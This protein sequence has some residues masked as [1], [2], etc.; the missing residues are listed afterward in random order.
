MKTSRLF[1][2]SMGLLALC[3][4]SAVTLITAN[5]SREVVSLQI[6][7]LLSVESPLKPVERHS[8]D[9]G[10]EHVGNPALIP[11]LP[12]TDYGTTF[13]AMNDHDVPCPPSDAPDVVY[14]YVPT[15]MLTVNVSLCGSS[16]NTR[17]FAFE[18]DPSHAVACN[19]DACGMQS[20][21]NDL[22]LT[23]GHQYFFVVDGF[24]VEAGDYVINIAEAGCNVP[25]QPGDIIECPETPNPYHYAEDCDGGCH[26]TPPVFGAILP[27][28]PLCGVGFTYTCS[29]GQNCR[30]TDWHEFVVSQTSHVSILLEA[31]FP[32][33]FGIVDY[34]PCDSADLLTYAQ[35][36]EV[37]TPTIITSECLPP[38]NYVAFVAPM[39]FTGVPVPMNYRATL[40]LETCEPPC[41]GIISLSEDS[42]VFAPAYIGSLSVGS[43]IV[44]N[45][46]TEPLCVDSVTTTGHVWQAIP[47]SFIV[48]PGQL[49][50]VQVNFL[51]TF[52]HAF[53]G[54]IEFFS[55]D[56]EKPRDSIIVSGTGCHPAVEPPGPILHSAACPTA[57]YFELPLDSN[58]EMTKYMVE[59]SLD[60]F[61]T[62]DVL[63]CYA[64]YEDDPFWVS[65]VHWGKYGQGVILDLEAS[66]TYQVR[67]H[68]KDC[69][70]IELIGPAASIATEPAIEVAT[71]PEL[72]IMYVNENT[73]RLHWNP[74]VADSAGNELPN[75]GY[76]VYIGDDPDTVD[77]LVDWSLNGTVDMALNSWQRGFLTVDPVLEGIYD[78]PCPFI[79]WPPEGA[80]VEGW[81]CIVLQDF[82]HFSQ[83]DSFRIEVNGIL[84]GSS[85]DNP[86]GWNSRR[87]SCIDFR[88][89]SSG[90]ATI[91]A[92]VVDKHN[93][94][95]E[96]MC[97]V[98]VFNSGF[99]DF[100]AQYDSILQRF[101]LDTLNIAVDPQ[102]IREIYWP[103]STAGE[104]YGGHI[105]FDWDT[106]RDSVTVVLPF[107]ILDGKI[108]NEEGIGIHNN[109][110]NK[111]AVVPKQAEPAVEKR[112]L[113]QCCE[114]VAITL[115]EIIHTCTRVQHKIDVGVKVEFTYR[116]VEERTATPTHGQDAKGDRVYTKG[117]CT[118]DAQDSVVFTP[119]P[120]TPEVPNPVTVHKRHNN[121]NYPYGGTE[122]GNDDYRG[123]EAKWDIN[124]NRLSW[125]DSPDD[126][127][128]RV[129]GQASRIVSHNKFKVWARPKCP[130]LANG[131]CCKTFEINWDVVCCKDGSTKV[132][133]APAITN[134]QPCEGE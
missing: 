1:R 42:L 24:G 88:E 23:P 64:P 35:V 119:N 121:T 100:D 77:S 90:P 67:L 39:Y 95:F 36:S 21:I 86:W 13:G 103:T 104:R 59:S 49:F 127:V 134:L 16:Y 80:T 83:W 122:W 37:C 14:V 5:P 73:I 78:Q 44:T 65:A 120:S 6:S 79:S 62:S 33:L 7:S 46:G 43:V 132:N 107:T 99:P 17:L 41:G 2:I 71:E 131:A 112:M 56:P 8:L 57:I 70:G 20:E 102:T 117:T 19:D 26:R 87:M 105:T 18:D 31:E 114:S 51:P 82:V 101:S 11:G 47:S 133:V 125:G 55:S 109:D 52:D 76:F 92:V 58:R 60:N 72:T 91:H 30:D 40:T 61:A 27:N 75:I 66:T 10:G 124:H 84:V 38:G 3:C 29:G 106:T 25:C 93:R 116:N 54:V 28:L 81:N 9:Q 113:G 63:P 126:P 89:V 111:V 115:G 98:T 129:K 22:P 50:P 32:V 97:Y 48:A 45:A 128:W 4:L 85:F 12:F 118:K 74:Q 96:D 123:G 108:L 53:E 94:V 69:T 34:Q 110:T 130:E 68:A 15:E